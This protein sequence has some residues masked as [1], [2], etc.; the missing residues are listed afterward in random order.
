[1]GRKDGLA[2]GSSPERSTMKKSVFKGILASEYGIMAQSE[3]DRAWESLQE[4]RQGKK[5]F[6]KWYAE[7]GMT[8]EI[9]T[10]KNILLR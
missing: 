6:W 2:A 7:N 8:E 1:M 9:K 4:V 3:I 10:Y 5:E